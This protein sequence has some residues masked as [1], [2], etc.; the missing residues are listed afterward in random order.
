MVLEQSGPVE[1]GPLEPAE[2][3]RP[4][5]GPGQV[6]I[7][8][9]VC[10]VCHTDLHTVEGELP[11]RPLP[12]I[13]G[14]QVVGVV[15]TLGAGAHRFQVGQRVGVAWLHRACGTCVYCRRGDE[16]LCFDGLFTGYDVPGGYAEAL[17][18]DEDFA[19][20]LPS[21]LPDERI[22][23]LLCAGII[24]YRALRLS[25][26]AAG[27]RLGLYGFG[28]SAHVTIQ[29]ARHLGC[30]V[31][32]FSR[33]D[34]HRDLARR[35]GAEWCGQAE[36]APP[37]K[38][39][40]SIVFAPAGGLVPLALEHL[41][42][43]GTCALAGIHMSPV[44]TLDY[45]RHLYFERTLRSVTASTRTDG[46]ELL[47]LAGEAAVRTHV[48]TFPLEMANQALQQLKAGRITGAAVLQV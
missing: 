29:I 5:P 43:G 27:Q 9:S 21:G 3:E 34:S 7:A 16:N 46:Q 23:P 42:R 22:A 18:V 20:D 2:V 38:L 24:G 26:V 48:T 8:V 39:D 36:D 11:A 1:D 14:H 6:R 13:P 30:R 35:L 28:A 40:G 45:E 47:R 41:D 10:G 17:V 12:I 33:S 19:Y 32:V 37:E 44:P 4:E 31:F 15:D 25:N